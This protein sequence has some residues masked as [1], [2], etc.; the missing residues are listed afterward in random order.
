MSDVERPFGTSGPY[1]LYH[2]D[3]KDRTHTPPYRLEVIRAP[4]VDGTDRY[5]F[6][7]E[8]ADGFVLWDAYKRGAE[9]MNEA[10]QWFADLVGAALAQEIGIVGIKRYSNERTA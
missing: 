10:T 1:G 3:K 8:S 4:H 7:V 9:N 2:I 5:I 6:S